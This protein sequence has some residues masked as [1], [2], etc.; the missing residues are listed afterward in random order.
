MTHQGT[1]RAKIKREP[2]FGEYDI[3]SKQRKNCDG[4]WLMPGH[5]GWKSCVERE[6]TR[7]GILSDGRVGDKIKGER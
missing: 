1:L 7:R 6:E 2:F 4:E 3:S 5:E